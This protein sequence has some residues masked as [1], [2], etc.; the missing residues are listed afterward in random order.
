[1]YNGN[2]LLAYV[3]LN[4]GSVSHE[5]LSLLPLGYGPINWFKKNKNIHQC[6]LMLSE[7]GIIHKINNIK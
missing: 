1:M 2:C 3:Y 4:G 5:N 7:Q 6:H